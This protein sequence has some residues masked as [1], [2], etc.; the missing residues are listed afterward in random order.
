MSKTPSEYTVSPSLSRPHRTRRCMDS[1]LSAKLADKPVLKYSA[2]RYATFVVSKLWVVVGVGQAEA[3][4]VPF[5]I[6][7]ALE[8]TATPLLIAR[9]RRSRAPTS[10]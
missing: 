6:R 5:F 4:Q 10:L 1:G 7:R 9:I 3:S 2:Q 8:H